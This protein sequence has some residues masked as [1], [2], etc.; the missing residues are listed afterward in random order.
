MRSYGLYIGGEEREEN[1]WTYTIA[2]EKWIDEPEQTLT[3]KRSLE[4]GKLDASE[5]TDRIAAR[6]AVGTAKDNDFAVDAAYRASH[7]F[8]QFPLAVRSQIVAS[9]RDRMISQQDELLKILVDEGHPRKLGEWEI[10]G[11]INGLHPQ[12]LEWLTNQMSQTFQA[13]DKDIELVRKPDGVVCVSPPQ[14]AAA[15][16][17]ALGI[18]GLLAG[19]T[20]VVKAPR[21]CPLGVHYV[22]REIVDPVLR[23]YGAPAGT[24]NIVS[25]ESSRILNGWLNNP[26]VSDL[27]YF[28]GSRAGLKIGNDCI[29]NGKKPILELAG[30]DPFIVWEDADLEAASDA[31]LE[32][33]YGS[34]QICMVPKFVVLH[35]RITDR[36]LELFLPK[37]RSIKP[38]Y[39]NESEV[40]LSPV[41][42]A[43]EFFEYLSDAQSRGAEL[44]SGGNR[45]DIHGQTSHKGAFVEPSVI[46]ID[47][48]EEAQNYPSVME[49]TFFPLLSVVVPS[50]RSQLLEDV[51][52][53]IQRNPYGLRNSFWSQDPGVI[54]TYV[55][56]VSNVGQIKVNQSHIGFV[57]F[58][59]THGGTGLTGGP[60]GELNYVAL[61]T[62]HLQGIS[63]NLRG[64]A[65]GRSESEREEPS[66][67]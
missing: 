14:N 50:Q 53:F 20:L 64:C 65:T 3:L 44:L 15:S 6:C 5:Y 13:D 9:I 55:R 12:T 23:E 51:I 33:F 1:K 66:S 38:G 29:A 31:L 57:P 19:N 34:S 45:V 42:K 54:E 52:A 60:F 59:S 67:T 7:V 63:Y 62:S 4:L 39:P 41:L 21:S 32:S 16:N 17:S 49:E 37:V 28:G 26:K 25:G 10:D 11:M 48:L 8:G 46:R 2:A 61:R 47:S 27:F 24:V 30:N 43:H 56:A 18:Y 58:I 22:Y 35:P 36:F 40:I